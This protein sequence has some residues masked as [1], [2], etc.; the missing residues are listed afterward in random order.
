MLQESESSL[1]LEQYLKNLPS[2]AETKTV[3]KTLNYFLLEQKLSVKQIAQLVKELLMCLQY[4]HSKDIVHLNLNPQNILVLAENAE[5]FFISIEKE[6]G[7][8][9]ENESAI[10]LD[11]Q[12]K[13]LLINFC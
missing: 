7:S 11:V 6:F 9:S 8:K 3:P 4:M 2:K 12:S 5:E 1:A 13:I 10:G